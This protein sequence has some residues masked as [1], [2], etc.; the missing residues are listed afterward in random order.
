MGKCRA[1]ETWLPL[2]RNYLGNSFTNF[3]FIHEITAIF[4]LQ[5]SQIF[6]DYYEFILMKH[7]VWKETSKIA[8]NLIEFKPIHKNNLIKK[9]SVALKNDFAQLS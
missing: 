4:M 7:L 3:Q 1:A 8:E 5:N 6:E 9:V 2:F